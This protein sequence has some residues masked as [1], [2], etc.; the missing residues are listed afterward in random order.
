MTTSTPGFPVNS[1]NDNGPVRDAL[2]GEE[3]QEASE[4]TIGAGGGTTDETTT[5]F[6]TDGGVPV[7]AADAEAD[8]R[9]TETDGD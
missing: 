1:D 8:R 6:G 5:D 7:G 2:V 9:R 4:G 3:G